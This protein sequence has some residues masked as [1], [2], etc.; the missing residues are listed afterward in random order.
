MTGDEMLWMRFL[1]EMKVRRQRVLK[2]MHDEIADQRKDVGAI[3]GQFHR[4]R[5][6]FEDRRGQH[7]SSSNGEKILQILARPFA[8][9]DEQAAENV[10]RRSRQTQTQGQQHPRSRNRN[11]LR[12]YH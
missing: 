12:D 1:S 2:K 4:F 7:E 10:G 5:K 11:S 6:N 8:V 3:A 9:Q